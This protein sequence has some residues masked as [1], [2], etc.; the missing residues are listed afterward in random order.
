MSTKESTGVML[1]KNAFVAFEVEK[2][3]TGAGG[4]T[5]TTKDWYIVPG[6]QGL[7][8]SN[9]NEEI[10]VTDKFSSSDFKENMVISLE[11][12]VSLEGQLKDDT[13]ALKIFDVLRKK[14]LAKEPINTRIII[15]SRG[16]GYEGFY[17][18]GLNTEFPHDSQG[19]YTIELK[20]S[21]KVTYKESNIATG[22]VKP[23]GTKI[24]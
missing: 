7:S 19:T 11:Q 3:T 9:S 15:D 22:C 14:W 2:T 18:I 17:T 1:G 12:S 13:E 23:D 20:P 24:T 6:Q 5:T 10:D 16:Y 8:E 21:K 4:T